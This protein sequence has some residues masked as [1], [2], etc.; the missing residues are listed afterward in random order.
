MSGGVG[1]RYLEDNHADM[2]WTT[3]ER[4]GI[5]T[6]GKQCRGVKK[7]GRL[8]GIVWRGEESP[9]ATAL[10]RTFFLTGGPPSGGL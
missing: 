8:S 7:I 3:N 2:G 4:V 1:A 5:Q 10:R 6:V 9:S